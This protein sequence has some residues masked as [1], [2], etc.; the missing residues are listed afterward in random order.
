MAKLGL[1]F[2]FYASGPYSSMVQLGRE[3]EDAGYDCLLVH[4]ARPPTTHCC[5]A[6]C[7]RPPPSRS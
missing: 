1:N 7:W 4:E 5:A 3:A 2:P 6:R